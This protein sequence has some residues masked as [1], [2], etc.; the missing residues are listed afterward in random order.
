[1]SNWQKMALEAIGLPNK[2]KS[3]ELLFSVIN[4]NSVDKAWPYLKYA[5]LIND[6]HKKI[7]IYQRAYD[8]EPNPYS[9]LGAL[10][11]NILLNNTTEAVRWLDILRTQYPDNDHINK[12]KYLNKIQE[13][14]PINF[15][16]DFYQKAHTELNLKSETEAILHYLEHGTNEKREY[17]KSKYKIKFSNY[18][19]QNIILYTQYYTST[20]QNDIDSVLKNNIQNLLINKIILFCENGKRPPSTITD[21]ASKIEFIDINHRW[22]TYQ[23]WLDDIVKYPDSVKILSNSDIFF[24]ST[25]NIINYIDWQDNSLYACSRV[26]I[27]KK[28]NII[29]SRITWDENS[30]KINPLYSQDC[31]I[32]KYPLQNLKSNLILGYENCDVLFKQ[33]CL[34]S[35][36]GFINLSNYLRIIHMDYRNIKIRPKYCLVDGSINYHNEHTNNWHEPAMSAM[37][38]MQHDVE[39]AILLL[40]E[41][42]SL[43]PTESWPFIKLADTQTNVNRKIELLEK[44]I[45]IDGAEWAY[46]LLIKTLINKNNIDEAKKNY[47]ILE[48]F[49]K[50]KKEIEQDITNELKTLKTQIYLENCIY[51]R[52]HHGLANRLRTINSFYKFAVKHNKKL[53]IYWGPGPGWSDETFHELFCEINNHIEFIDLKTFCDCKV[54]SINRYFYRTPNAEYVFSI[55]QSEL[56]QRMVSQSF[57]Y[58]GDSCLEYLFDNYKDESPNLFYDL[59][60]PVPSLTQEI[61]KIQGL[62]NS[63]NTIGIHV[64]RGDSRF[65]NFKALFQPSEDDTFYKLI[66]EEIKKDPSVKF[67]LSTDCSY[68]QKKFEN[69]YDKYLIYNKNKKFLKDHDIFY[70]SKSHQRDAVLDLWLLSLTSK[71]IGSKYSSLS[72]L[73]G[74]LK[75]VEVIYEKEKEAIE[76]NLIDR[77]V[78]SSTLKIDCELDWQF[79]AYTEKQAFINHQNNYLSSDNQVYVGCPWASII[80]HIFNNFAIDV[81]SDIFNNDQVKNYLKKN[82]LDKFKKE[83]AK[84]YYTV[85]Q[86]IYWQKLIKLWEIMGIN[87]VYVSH[88]TDNFNNDLVKFYPW[89]LIACN[90]E[91]PKRNQ[92]LTIK[93]IK[94]KKYLCSFVGAHKKHYLSNTRKDLYNIYLKL[95]NKD[96]IYMQ[97][98]DEWFLNDIVYENQIHKYN[99]SESYLDQHQFETIK[100]NQILSD[101]IF[102]L[103]PEGAGPNTIRL[104]ESMSVGS[105]PVLFENN[106]TRPA[107][108][109]IGWDDFSITIPKKDIDHTFEILDIVS[110]SR[111][112]EMRINAINAYNQVRLQT[113]F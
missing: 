59:L 22:L 102:S 47:L 38:L 101:S 86:H 111:I 16:A 24:D 35:G 92:D 60:Q 51:L 8:V 3:K 64:R 29:D 113:C 83:P 81:N 4:D 48:D 97:I 14:L 54:L 105:I 73:A 82:I 15:D 41:S 1:M 50:N 37:E 18:V 75:N 67:Y 33:H 69:L 40:E 109:N 26:D 31:W 88:L 77:K 27:N 89:H 43:S 90:A 98:N 106:W 104:G 44:A 46:I 5:D 23:D 71:I 110:L 93:T 13:L 58:F 32:T 7:K 10:N 84:Q 78:K 57:T 100:Y 42:V 45:S 85:C 99:I 55:P 28:N 107:V 95:K 2:E 68:T 19:K 72:T 79:P 76:T 25:L 21:G 36:Y 12:F 53:K 20:N 94:E 112:E 6:S 39:K 80:D 62:F 11:C 17:C 34:D 9:C 108:K 87:N 91:N 70:K 103:C 66:D 61:K 63:T 96:K 49:V 30:Q 56:I 74:K 65:V 52:V